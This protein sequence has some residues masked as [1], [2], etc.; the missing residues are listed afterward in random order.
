MTRYLTVIGI[1]T[2]ENGRWEPHR[3]RHAE[4]TMKG[5]HACDLR[6]GR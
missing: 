6:K 5:N 4:G 3:Q 1:V 2:P